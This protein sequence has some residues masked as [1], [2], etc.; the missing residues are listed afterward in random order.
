MLLIEGGFLNGRSSAGC[1][2][3]SGGQ[4]AGLGCDSSSFFYKIVTLAAPQTAID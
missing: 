3:S 4:K 1:C 2:L